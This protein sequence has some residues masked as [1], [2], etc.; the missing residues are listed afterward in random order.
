M[1]PIDSLLLTGLG[2][3]YL[4]F[5]LWYDGRGSP[6]SAAEIESLLA[7]IKRRA[8]RQTQ[9]EGSALLQQLRE[10]GGNDD[11]RDFSMVNLLKFRQSAL[12]PQTALSPSGTPYGDDPLAANNRYNRLIVPILLKHGSHP[13]FM[14]QVQGRF[15]HPGGGEDW[16]Q[17]GIVR[18]RSRRDLL[19]WQPTLLGPAQTFISGPPWKRP[20]FFR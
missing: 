14:G 8:G 15:I 6:L 7:E 10:L 18:Y 5:W 1:S 2:L 9:G 3:L 13:V 11:G 16:D 17:V 12:Y 19:K 20:W 4:A